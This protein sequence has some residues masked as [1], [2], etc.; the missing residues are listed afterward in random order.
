VVVTGWLSAGS[1]TGPS[2]W[3]RLVHG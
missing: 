2:W 3:W 1:L